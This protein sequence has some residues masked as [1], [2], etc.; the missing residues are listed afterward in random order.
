M[1]FNPK[2][3]LNGLL[4]SKGDKFLVV[5]MF[6]DNNRAASIK[7]NFKE[8]EIKFLKTASHYDLK[9][10]LKKFGRISRYKIVLGLDSHLA[11]TIYSS[12]VLARDRF[13]ELID[14][15]EI[16]NLISQAIWKFFDR[17]RNKVA[18]KMAVSD[19]DIV[20][21]DVKILGVRLDGHKVV[22]PVGFKAKTVEVMFSQTFLLRS[23]VDSVKEILPLDQVL[24]TTES[25]TAWSSVM[26]K[27]DT[28]QNFLMANIFGE[29]TA[30]F[31]SAGTQNSYWD[32]FAWGEN[33]L[34]AG[35]AS[36]LALDSE[37]AKGVIGLYNQGA[38]SD[39]FRRRVETMISR[40]LQTLA[41]GL[42]Q[43]VKKMDVKQIF[44]HSFF[45]LPAIFT[46]NFRD[47]FDK[48][49]NLRMLNLDIISNNFG[50]DIKFKYK[51][52]AK[53]SFSFL[54]TLLE[55]YLAPREDKMSQMAKRRVRWLSPV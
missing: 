17:Q 18:S 15:P 11:T 52:D 4:K 20:L 34:Y 32:H 53:Y 33:N 26:A 6:A 36:D 51:A 50:F 13:K 9:K 25:G 23:F 16:D 21:S 42:N 10:L 3:I 40:E 45:D 54:A 27:S 1:N 30:M 7:A 31:A 14:E 55:W 8:K 19:L 12:V 37:T 47:S 44:L 46:T 38:T 28:G 29:K 39:T 43:V 41:N 24:F 49:V 48:P 35:L 22:N 2:H 5:E